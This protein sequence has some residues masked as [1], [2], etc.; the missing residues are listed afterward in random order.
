MTVSI[1]GTSLSGGFIIMVFYILSR[2][3]RKMCSAG[4]RKFGWI[5][6]AVF[7]I[8]PIQFND[9]PWTYKVSIPKFVAEESNFTYSRKKLQPGQNINLEFSDRQRKEAMAIRFNSSEKILYI[10][11]LSG[12]ILWA[13]YYLTGYYRMYHRM[14]RWSRDCGRELAVKASKIALDLGLKMVPEIRI[15]ESSTEGPFTMG[16]IKSVIYLPDKDLFE[17]DLQYILKHELIHC[18]EKDIL[19]K[20]L[21]LTANIIHWF[22]PFVWIMRRF[23][24][25]DVEQAC[26]ERV[27]R[28]ATMEECREYSDVILSWVMAGRQNPL[29]TG[30]VAGTILLKQRFANIYA[31]YYR[32]SGKNFAVIIFV[33][34]LIFENMIS[35]EKTDNE[36]YLSESDHD[37]TTIM[38]KYAYP[39]RQNMYW[40]IEE[41]EYDQMISP[42]EVISML[43]EDGYLPQ[44]MEILNFWLNGTTAYIDLSNVEQD[45]D[46][47]YR[48]DGQLQIYLWTI[49]NSLCINDM[50]RIENVYFLVDHDMNPSLG[51]LDTTLQPFKNNL[52][53]TGMFD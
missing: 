7:L 34:I 32:K 25:N 10:I 37:R 41:R 12:V 16:I 23:A 9:M 46:G 53:L 11:W 17:K 42:V 4:S 50:F 48:G 28:N 33:M 51:V 24:E 26:D 22:N 38:I 3:F 20:L 49:I 40:V 6:I 14:K 19:W 44:D 47:N 15:M 52:E 13:V 35:I 30:Y 18:K 29:S 5:L 39:D 45:S 8:V 43:K 21:F 31:S 1:L 36:S 2:I 27:L